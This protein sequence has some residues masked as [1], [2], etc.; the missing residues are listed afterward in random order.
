MSRQPVLICNNKE[1]LTMNND[2]SSLFKISILAINYLS[3]FKK[4]LFFMLLLTDALTV[5]NLASFPSLCI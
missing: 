4:P 1:M 5:L 2:V 3:T